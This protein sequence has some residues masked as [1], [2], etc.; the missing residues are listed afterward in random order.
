LVAIAAL[1]TGPARGVQSMI[2]KSQTGFPKR[3]CS[4]K[5][6]EGDDDSTETHRAM[7]G[8]QARCLF[9]L[10]AMKKSIVL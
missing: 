10:L 3:S 9:L 4:I 7:A 6:L 2:G 8:R 5:Y 1:K